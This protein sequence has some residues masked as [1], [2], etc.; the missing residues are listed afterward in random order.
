MLVFEFTCPRGALKIIKLE[1]NDLKNIVL[2]TRH[3]IS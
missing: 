1:R 2:I 3:E